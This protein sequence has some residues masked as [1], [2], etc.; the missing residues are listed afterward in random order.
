MYTVQHYP[1]L[2]YR[3]SDAYKQ[4]MKARQ[5]VY[6]FTD[7]LIENKQ[8]ELATRA[9]CDVVDDQDDVTLKK[10][11]V[12]IEQ[13]LSQRNNFNDIEIKDNMYSMIVAG[14]DTSQ[15][16]T[17]YALLFLAMHPDFQDRVFE[18]LKE[19]F[20]SSNM[21]FDYEALKSLPYLDM[22]LKE[23]L[24]LCPVVPVIARQSVCAVDIGGTKYPKGSIF[25]IN[26]FGMHRRQEIWGVNAGQFN[27]ENFASEN[28]VGRHPHAYMPYAAGTRSC[29]GEKYS[30]LAIK[31]LLVDIL[32]NYKIKT[33]LKYE[34]LRFKSVITLKLLCSHFVQIEKRVP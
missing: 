33:K 31:T 8:R 34:E 1:D 11:N 25:V 20:I 26:L 17:A 23:T 5:V 16:I 10:P 22:V 27:P 32:L 6:K 15:L 19:V 28:L 29:I 2:I 12:F 4:E 14:N 9:S 21:P 30:Q 3:F 18:E 24:R 13:L 7:K